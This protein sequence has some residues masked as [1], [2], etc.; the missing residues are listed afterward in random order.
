MACYLQFT[1]ITY[2]YECH[3][4]FIIIGNM[5][6]TPKS[7]YHLLDMACYLQFTDIN[8]Y[9]SKLINLHD[10]SSAQ[11]KIPIE[12]AF[13]MYHLALMHDDL[14]PVV[15][16]SMKYMCENLPEM[17]QMDEFLNNASHEFLLE[18]LKQEN[19][20]SQDEETEV[21]IKLKKLV[22]LLFF[23]FSLEHSSSVFITLTS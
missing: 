8:K 5:K 18:Y 3:I 23:F 21:G 9:C 19:L 4:I 16:E 10:T 7:A 20:S 22:K 12:D 11:E 15:K 6:I 2:H 14:E 17:R 1:D 13:K